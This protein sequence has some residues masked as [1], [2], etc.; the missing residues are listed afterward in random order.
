MSTREQAAQE[1]MAEKAAKTAA[2]NQDKVR[3]R[4]PEALAARP[5]HSHRRA[6][7]AASS[8]SGDRGDDD[9]DGEGAVR[10]LSKAEILVLT[11]LS[12]PTIWQWMRDGRFPRARV[13]GGKSCWLSSEVDAWITALPVRRLKGDA[14][15][16][17]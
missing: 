2:A 3:P 16:A 4:Y 11:G 1:S 14:D 7:N 9:G 8:R 15:V 10:L 5:R 13:L 12:F 17:A 6:D